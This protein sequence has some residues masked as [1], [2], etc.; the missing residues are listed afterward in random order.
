MAHL[1][2]YALSV[3]SLPRNRTVRLAAALAAM[4]GLAAALP[5][6]AAPDGRRLDAERRRTGRCPGIIATIGPTSRSP[7]VLRWMM[8]AGLSIARINL[9]HAD[10]TSAGAMT[11]S[12]REAARATGCKPQ[13]LFDLPGGK[14][15]T[16]ALERPVELRTGQPFDL[17][18]GSHRRS[19]A[20]QTPVDYELLPRHAAVGDRIVLGDN[21]VELEVTA[22]DRDRVATRV[23]RGGDLRGRAGVHIEGKELPFPELTERDREKL[24]IAVDNGATH[25]G[26][27]MVQ[28]PHQLRA[29]RREL[30]RLG[31]P[32]STKIVAKIETRSALEHLDEIIAES[33]MV[34]IAR[35][36]LAQAVGSEAA[37]REAERRIAERSK[38]HGKPFIN[39]TGFMSSMVGG[40]LRPTDANLRDVERARAMAP[41]HLML[42]ETA[43]AKRPVSVLIALRRALLGKQ[44]AR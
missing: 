32:R 39:A 11:R 41:S 33:D 20:R 40:A 25:I 43:I 44:K 35:G 42:N 37:L 27:S 8:R 4:A 29:V 23:V 6:A 36:D 10:A 12:I 15:R 28:R 9:S 7:R 19:D 18:V 13:L 1:L 24:P 17:V 2:L 14:V 38:A 26:V 21:E 3:V 16:G 34:M 31:A 22:T 30:E 5:A